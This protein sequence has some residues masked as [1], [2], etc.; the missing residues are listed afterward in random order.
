MNIHR[1]DG[2][3]AGRW[4]SGWDPGIAVQGRI[5]WLAY[6]NQCR[7]GINEAKLSFPKL[8]NMLF[9]I[10]CQIIVLEHTSVKFCRA[11]MN[12]AV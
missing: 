2:Y 10:T 9:P 11:F 4:I 5:E 1:G 7:A 8:K 12:G 3:Q 6:D